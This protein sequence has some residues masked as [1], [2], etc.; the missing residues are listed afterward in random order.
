MQKEP[1]HVFYAVIGKDVQYAFE[2]G[3]G[4]GAMLVPY[5]LPLEMSVRYAFFTWVFIDRIWIAVSL[6]HVPQCVKDLTMAGFAELRPFAPFQLKVCETIP[7]FVDSAISVKKK[8]DIQAM[9]AWQLKKARESWQKTWEKSVVIMFLENNFSF[10]KRAVDPAQRLHCPAEYEVDRCLPVNEFGF[11]FNMYIKSR[12]T[13][14]VVKYICIRFDPS[15][16][17]IHV[18]DRN[19]AYPALGLDQNFDWVV[20]EN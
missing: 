2:K 4:K 11:E 8:P 13:N 19:R 18:M 6:T 7:E 1:F 20:E 10:D 15:T 5:Q 16:Q 14:K 3:T 12:A 17:R 9:P